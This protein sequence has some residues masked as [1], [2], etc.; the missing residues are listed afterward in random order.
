MTILI[1]G[2]GSIAKKHIKVITEVDRSAR[3]F[4]FRSSRGGESVENVTDIY[5][6]SDLPGRP[7]F[8]LISNPTS[9]HYNTIKEFLTLEV[10]LFIEKPPLMTMDSAFALADEIE[11][12]GVRTYVAFNL[13][14]HPMIEFLKKELLNHHLLE[15][16]IYA[17]SYLPD[18]RPGRD[19]TKVYSAKAELGGGVH[20]DLIHELDYAYWLF[21]NP[22]EVHAT[23][24]KIST[25]DITSYDYAHYQFNYPDKMIKIS[26]NYFRK[27][28]KRQIELVFSDKTW[29]ANLQDATIKDINGEIIYET[30]YN[31]FDTYSKQMNYF[32]KNLNSDL[33]YM[34]NFRESLIVLNYCLHE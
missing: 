20:L 13:R 23:R 11:K 25:L 24:R 27:D 14:F 3:L 17:G 10:P 29:I 16:N 8:V 5:N 30:T 6:I 7:D 18:W 33:P 31:I 1:I 9:L 2:L 28:V 19:Y 32:L 34:N 26:M 15:A 22:I 4:A 12:K 21:G